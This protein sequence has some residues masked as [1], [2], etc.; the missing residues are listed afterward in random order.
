MTRGRARQRGQ[1]AILIAV[2]VALGI[3]GFILTATS[4]TSVAIANRQSEVD[5]QVLAIAKEALIGYAVSQTNQPGVLPCPDVDNDGSADAPCGG[6]GATAIG[7][8]PWKTLGMPDLRDSAGEC[9]WYAVSS[10]FKNSGV[11][12]PAVVNSDSAGTLVVN[13][14]A[15]VPLS[16]PPNPVAA[17]V[18]APGKLLAGQDRTP[19]AS[20]ATVCGGN[21]VATNYLE[22]GNASAGTTYAAAGPAA[23]FNDRLLLITNADVLIPVERRASAE[24]LQKLVDYRN[25]SACNCYPWADNNWNGISN[26]GA[27]YGGV[28]LV[29]ASPD[30]WVSATGSNPAA[31]LSTNQWYKVVAYAVS[32]RDSEDGAFGD[33]RF[34]V[35]STTGVRVVVL[36]TGSAIAGDGRPT[37]NWANYV[38]DAENRDNDNTFMTPL[39]TA[40]VRD[41]I[42]W[43]TSP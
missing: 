15:G 14:S 38:D 34:T 23:T 26:T 29:T 8:F 19:P 6:I 42:Y 2:L 41:R 27:R 32:I 28:P 22:E 30:S 3:G 1:A 39:S 33:P 20:P 17:I 4:S 18:F 10:N 24:I 16:S 11:S 9:L 40:Y 5:T 25:G 36:T 21:D 37:S 43:R 12:G 31:W 7:R 35:D 13:G